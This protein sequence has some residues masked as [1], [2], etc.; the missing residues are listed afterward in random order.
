M[1]FEKIT[2]TLHVINIT[3]A[4]QRP[5]LSRSI[6]AVATDLFITITKL[7]LQG[8]NFNFL[9]GTY[10]NTPSKSIYRHISPIKKPAEA[11]SGCSRQCSKTCFL[12]CFS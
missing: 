12:P 7:C 5:R 9:T 8:A 10:L 3:I 1:S 11:G 4:G 2:Y 6:D